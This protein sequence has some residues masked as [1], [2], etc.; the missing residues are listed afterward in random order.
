MFTE[1][2]YNDIDVRVEDQRWTSHLKE[3]RNRTSIAHLNTRSLLKSF[4]EFELMLN[5]YK[6]DMLALTETW[7]PDNEHAINYAQIPEYN[8]EINNRNTGNTYL[9]TD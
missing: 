1:P 6:F 9:T 4:A 8:L 5:T 7:L 3:N 2:T